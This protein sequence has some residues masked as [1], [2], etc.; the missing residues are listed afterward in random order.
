MRDPPLDP[1]LGSPVQDRRAPPPRPLTGASPSDGQRRP[2]VEGHSGCF[3]DVR[4]GNRAD[5]HPANCDITLKPCAN[6]DADPVGERQTPN[7][8]PGAPDKN[9]YTW[10]EVAYVLSMGNR[11]ASRA[12]ETFRSRGGIL[13]TK[14]ALSLGVHP[15]SERPH[16]GPGLAA[17]LRLYSPCGP[18][19]PRDGHSRRLVLG[20][21][22]AV[23]GSA[24]TGL[25]RGSAGLWHRHA[26]PRAISTLRVSRRTTKKTK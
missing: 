17:G 20:S 7:P 16:T 12:I 14:E 2:P 6:L 4:P 8:A 19:G 15:R 22:S 10:R 21:G 11:V 26:A 18:P 5:S 23:D 9:V 24:R 3:R 13:R 25:R 1:R